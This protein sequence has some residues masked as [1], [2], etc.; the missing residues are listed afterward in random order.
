MKLASCAPLTTRIPQSNA[1]ASA[2][3]S[4]SPPPTTT[5]TT[6]NPPRPA[7]R[8]YARVGI[9]C[10]MLSC[11]LKRTS[12]LGMWRWNILPATCAS[13]ADARFSVTGEGGRGLRRLRREGGR[14][15]GGATEPSRGAAWVAGQGRRGNVTH[16]PRTSE[17]NDACLHGKSHEKAH[18][19]GDFVRWLGPTRRGA[20]ASCAAARLKPADA[21]VR[22]C[23]IVR[24]C[25]RACVR[26]V[27]EARALGR[28]D[29]HPSLQVGL[30]ELEELVLLV[31]PV[32]EPADLF[33]VRRHA[34]D[35]R[36]A[37]L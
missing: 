9:T 37:A 22:T 20:C 6:T 36:R 34:S 35:S 21:R 19:P 26:A 18:A 28:K 16:I 23:G 30:Q 4:S 5:F 14:G 17:Q 11:C 13:V 33:L 27:R 12:R 8:G 7:R 15:A 31:E 10:D 25:V 29:W 32:D 24:A 2:S 3:H 1:G